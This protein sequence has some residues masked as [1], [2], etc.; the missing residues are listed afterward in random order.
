MYKCINVKMTKGRKSFW[1]IRRFF[2]SPKPFFMA[3]T[4]VIVT[5]EKV[6]SKVK[7]DKSFSPDKDEKE[8]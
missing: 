3:V 1:S 6:K 2:V 4:I 8:R 7:E 5:I